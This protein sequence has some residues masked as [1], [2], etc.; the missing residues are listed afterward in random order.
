MRIRAW[1]WI[2]AVIGRE[3]AGLVTC[4][5]SRLLSRDSLPAVRR[6]TAVEF[7]WLESWFWSCRL[8]GFIYSCGLLGTSS[9]P[10]GGRM[11]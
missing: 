11:W 8:L 6:R 4:A 3:E 9:I 5:K 2:R 7:T 10:K 1:I